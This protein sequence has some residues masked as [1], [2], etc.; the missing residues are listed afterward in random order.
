MS[1]TSSRS[2]LEG[3]K[4]RWKNFV[5]LLTKRRRNI[6]K[7]DR[8]LQWPKPMGLIDS[9]TNSKYSNRL[10]WSNSTHS[11]SNFLLIQI[12]LLFL[13]LYSISTCIS[14][15]EPLTVKLLKAST[16]FSLAWM[17]KS[18]WDIRLADISNCIHIYSDSLMKLLKQ[19][20]LNLRLRA[21][22]QECLHITWAKHYMILMPITLTMIPQTRKLFSW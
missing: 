18:C 5:C 13:L 17:I 11:W 1:C 19:L 2:L 22:L 8:L 16:C 12:L 20:K 6:G 21:Q 10:D 9:Y 4:E 3:G 7:A 15:G 14:P